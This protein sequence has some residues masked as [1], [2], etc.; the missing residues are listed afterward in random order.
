MCALGSTFPL[1]SQQFP[2]HLKPV[3]SDRTGDSPLG[4]LNLGISAF[5]EVVGLNDKYMAALCGISVKHLP[6]FLFILFDAADKKHPVFHCTRHYKR[7]RLHRL[8]SPLLA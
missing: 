1:K 6:P 8:L 2:S 5:E 3:S 7:S 4:Q